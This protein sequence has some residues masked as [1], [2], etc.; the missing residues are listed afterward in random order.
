L[1]GSVTHLF[2]DGTRLWVEAEW[3]KRPSNGL[4]QLA[5][6]DNGTADPVHR[7]TRL[8][9]ELRNFS[10]VGPINHTNRENSQFT[11]S[12]EHRIN[13]IWN[14]KLAASWF[15]RDYWNFTS[16]RGENYN[17]VTRQ[18]AGRV[19]GMD[20]I[21]E[22]GGGFSADVLATYPL[23]GGKLRASTLFTLDYNVYIRTDPS[24][25]IPD[26]TPY[27]NARH[28]YPNLSVD[29]PNYA[30]VWPFNTRDYSQIARWNDDHTDDVGLAVRQQLN[31]FDDRLI[32][33]ASGRFDETVYRLLDKAA[34]MQSGN[35]AL[36]H[37]AYFDE[38]AFEPGGGASYEVHKNIRLYANLGSSFFANSQGV[39]TS[40][41]QPKEG[42]YGFDYGVK[43]S[44]LEN[45]LNGTLAA[46]YARQT[47][48]QV[49]DLDEN[50]FPVTR[51][52]GGR[53]TRGF[54]LDCNWQASPNATLLANYSFSNARIS[55]NGRD[56]DSVGRHPTQA[57]ENSASLVCRYIFP[58]GALKGLN[59]N[60]GIAYF[61]KSWIDAVNG[62]IVDPRT[63]LILSND[64]RRNITLPAYTLVNLG[65]Q[66]EYR[67]RRS[68]FAHT[69][70]VNVKNLL[71]KRYISSGR[72]VGDRLG[73]YFSYSINHFLKQ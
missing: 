69:F 7:Y 12:L 72:Y 17:P 60:L 64:G 27:V 1:M 70:G 37:R 48:V 44:F 46:Y 73:V 11:G 62:G 52:E 67:P 29:H 32:V 24:W 13:D 54:E 30:V 35:P 4:S 34:A 63:G 43:G 33:S 10:P 16:G 26:L 66:Y 6:V 14:L 20:N 25:R 19:P 50:G 53:L 9:T 28:Y 22:S 61:G 56:L 49:M 68:H 47:N 57:P 15:N 55:K 5:L 39:R 41:A 31:A 21:N 42:G 45:K 8:A 65:F 51:Y 3:I 71:D 36:T 2:S 23:H 58:A 59:V 18:I 38:N 40:A